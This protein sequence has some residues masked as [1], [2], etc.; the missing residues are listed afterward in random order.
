ME[1]REKESRV[2]EEEEL[3]SFKNMVGYQP[4]RQLYNTGNR[5]TR[6]R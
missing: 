5:E 2:S 1:G 6:A 3:K 4:V